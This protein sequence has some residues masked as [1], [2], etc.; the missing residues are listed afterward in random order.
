MGA[1]RV[2]A[3]VLDAGA[4]I[5]F[6]RGDGRIRALVRQGLEAGVRFV[7]PAGVLAQAWRDGRRQARLAALIG[8]DATAVELLDELGAK[9]AGALCGRSGSQDVVDASVAVAA[10]VYGAPVV[11]TDPRNLRRLDPGLDVWPL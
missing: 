9:A 1:R 2:A 6:D 3:V 7:V 11:T 5:E 8:D 4:L 10:R